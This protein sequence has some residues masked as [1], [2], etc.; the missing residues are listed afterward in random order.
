ME[1]EL[2][3]TAERVYRKLY[4][5]AQRCL[6]KNDQTNSRVT[7]FNMIDEAITTIIPSDPIDPERALSK[8]LSN[9]F[10]LK[11]G[12]WRICYIASSAEGRIVI[13][14]I[15]DTPQKEGD[16]NDPYNI[17]TKM[18]LAGRYDDLFASLGIKNPI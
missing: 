8:P 15:S 6:K 12:R 1:P 14:F 18:I 10:R 3:A 7:T 11:K 2:S 9:I 17:F 16:I 4:E 13:L 5:E